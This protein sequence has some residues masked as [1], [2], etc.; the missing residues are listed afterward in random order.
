[1]RSLLP[2]TKPLEARHEWI[3]TYSDL[4]RPHSL[5]LRFEE[6]RVLSLLALLCFAWLEE[7]HRIGQ[8]LFEFEV[9]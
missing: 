7:S 6:N 5:L 1:M 2:S 3:R 4:G 9:W 8:I